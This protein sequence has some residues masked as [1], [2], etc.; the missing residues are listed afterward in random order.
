MRIARL[1]LR[2]FG[3]LRETTLD[4]GRGL[5]VVYGPNDLGKSTLGKAIRAALLLPV[6]SSHAEAWV[7]WDR[8]ARPHVE[9]TLQ[10][11]EGRVWRITKTFARDARGT[12]LLESSADGLTFTVEARGR[13]VD[14]RLRDELRWG[15]ARPGG[16]G[17]TRGMPESFL[18][19][20]LLG[21]QTETDA[22]LARGVGGDG[23]E[24]GRA[25]LTDALEAF[26]QDPIF[27]AI[28]DAAQR[29][30]DAAFTARGKAKRGK[31]A[32]RTPLVEARNA[33]KGALEEAE[34]AW[35]EAE[36]VERELGAARSRWQAAE[37]AR[38]AAAAAK[39]AAE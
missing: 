9:L 20:V 5:N 33:A 26:A 34:R 32:P 30:V 8:D 35:W 28:L 37:A 16:K 13:E 7:P 17:G 36:A 38:R 21:E 2:D 12:S 4:F 15:I 22:I 1:A 25:L 18:A 6:T 19:K 14:Q 31:H 24:E 3:R 10:L 11:E 39:E 29:E 23:T 27:K